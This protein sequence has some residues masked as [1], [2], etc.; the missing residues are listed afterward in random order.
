MSW[1]SI[2]TA[3]V[4]AAVSAFLVI[5]QGWEP[6]VALLVLGGGMIVIILTV[7]AGILLFTPKKQRAQEFS[8]LKGGFRKGIEST[9]NSIFG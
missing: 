3:L 5:Y 4:L 9:I 6:W 1:T 2:I 8:E 7:L